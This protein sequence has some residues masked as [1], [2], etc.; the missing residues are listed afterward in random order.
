MSDGALYSVPCGSAEEEA[1][2]VSNFNLS[3]IICAHI[4]LNLSLTN[5]FEFLSSK[6]SGS[7]SGFWLWGRP[8]SDGEEEE[9]EIMSAILIAL[10]VVSASLHSDTVIQLICVAKGTGLG[11]IIKGGA[12]RTEGPMVFIQEIVPGGDCQKVSDVTE[13]RHSHVLWLTKSACPRLFTNFETEYESF[14]IQEIKTRQEQIMRREDGSR[15]HRS[16]FR[17]PWLHL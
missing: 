3:F 16:G 4:N 13:E 12:N 1:S 2:C 5:V 8:A 6:N 17:E 11:L 14:K 10:S 7:V 15:V 9:E